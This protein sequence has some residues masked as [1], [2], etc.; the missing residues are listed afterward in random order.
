MIV[1]VIGLTGK[2]LYPTTPAKARKLMEAG[3]AH[4]YCRTP[5]TIQLDYK[6]G[7]SAT[8]K[9]LVQIPGIST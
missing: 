5:F 3:K 6:T 9:K 7:G 4:V 1:F 2:R 8:P